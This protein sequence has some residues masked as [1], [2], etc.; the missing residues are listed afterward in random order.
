M[1]KIPTG[2]TTWTT[3][4][5]PRILHILLE[6]KTLS[7]LALIRPSKMKFVLEEVI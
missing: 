3:L 6:S 4:M 1:E 2:F 5:R 7:T